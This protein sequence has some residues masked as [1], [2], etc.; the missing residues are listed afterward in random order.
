MRFVRLETAKVHIVRSI[1]YRYVVV[2]NTGVFF[3]ED[4]LKLTLDLVAVLVIL[5][6][7]ANFVNEEKG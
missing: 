7:V 5:T 6:I 2:D 1:E 4:T 3:L